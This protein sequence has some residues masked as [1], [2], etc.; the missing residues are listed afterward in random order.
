MLAQ[1]VLFDG[2]DPLNVTAPYEV[3]GAGGM[4]MRR[5]TVWSA[6]GAAPLLDGRS[7]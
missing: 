1:I 6:R 2:S 5:G 7:A 3:L 4:G